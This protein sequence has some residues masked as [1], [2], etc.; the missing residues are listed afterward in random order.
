MF[1]YMAQVYQNHACNQLCEKL[2]T[3]LPQK[4]L[5]SWDIIFH[6]KMEYG[7]PVLAVTKMYFTA[8]RNTTL[9]GPYKNN[10]GNSTPVICNTRW[11]V[12]FYK[13]TVTPPFLFAHLKIGNKS[14]TVHAVTNSEVCECEQFARKR[15]GWFYQTNVLWAKACTA[16]SA[17]KLVT[18]NW[19]H[20]PVCAWLGILVTS[21]LI[22]LLFYF[23]CRTFWHY[24]LHTRKPFSHMSTFVIS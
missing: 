8:F 15:F 10:C 23:D 24:Q 12:I 2:K 3:A 11:D 4:C 21:A 7:W 17:A 9:V 19:A 14:L 1:V 18:P 13:C 16:L 6:R 5:T 20:T 22:R